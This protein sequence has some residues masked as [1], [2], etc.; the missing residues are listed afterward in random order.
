MRDLDDERAEGRNDEKEMLKCSFSLATDSDRKT[1][2]VAHP[3]HSLMQKCQQCVSIASMHYSLRAPSGLGSIT[4]W[5][6]VSRRRH[7]LAD[8]VIILTVNCRPLMSLHG[9][10]L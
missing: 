9:T 1:S 3:A 2:R 6:T 5:E 8:I 10:Q 4:S 7:A